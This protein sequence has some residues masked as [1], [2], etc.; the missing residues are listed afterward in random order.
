MG[1]YLIMYVVGVVCGIG[2]ATFIRWY[3]D[4][5]V[6]TIHID[7]ESIPEE[8]PYYFLELDEN[9]GDISQFQFVTFEVV[10]E[11]YLSQD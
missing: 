2:V 8:P 5:V 9:A 7:A 3:T 10:N 4:A 11:H 1:G 6:G